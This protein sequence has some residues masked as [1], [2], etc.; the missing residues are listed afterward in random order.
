MNAADPHVTQQ[1]P[2]QLRN[3]LITHRR[4][5]YPVPLLVRVSENVLSQTIKPIKMEVNWIKG[6]DV[7]FVAKSLP[8]TQPGEWRVIDGC[9]FRGKSTHIKRGASSWG[10]RLDLAL[11]RWGRAADFYAAAHSSSHWEPSVCPDLTPLWHIQPLHILVSRFHQH[12]NT[13]LKKTLVRL[14]FGQKQQVCFWS[15]AVISN[16]AFLS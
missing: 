5:T 10:D 12:A 4:I 2:V 9:L 1:L 16:D 8:I 15:V 7:S 3:T 6:S 14:S 11:R 13:N